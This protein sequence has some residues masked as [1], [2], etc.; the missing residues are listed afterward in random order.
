[1]TLRQKKFVILLI[2]SFA[3]AL[4]LYHLGYQ[5]FWSDE[6]ISLARASND[7]PAILINPHPEHMPLYF[8]LLHFWLIIVGSTDFIVRFLSLAFSFLVVP[9]LYR[10]GK[11]LFNYEVALWAATIAAINPFQTWYAQDARMYAMVLC[12][13]LGS[14]LL[15][16]MALRKKSAAAWAGYVVF[17]TLSIYT[18]YY[19]LLILLAEG[20]L[21]IALWLRGK[22]RDVVIGWLA[23]QV[24]IFVLY[25]PWLPRALHVPSLPVWREP[26]S[27]FSLPL[28]YLAAYSFGSTVPPSWSVPLSFGFLLILCFGLYAILKHQASQE[29]V[30]FSLLYLFVPTFLT[31][32]LFLYKPNYH[33]RYLIIITPAY[34]LLLAHGLSLLRKFWPPL[35]AL[36]LLFVALTSGYSLYNHYFDSSYGKADFRATARQIE[37]LERP[38][39]AILFDGST[40]GLLSHYYR[41]GLPIYELETFDYDDR[42]TLK[43]FL[44]RVMA[45]HHRLWVVVSDHE[46]GLVEYWLTAEAYQARTDWYNGIWLYLYSTPSQVDS[47]R[48]RQTLA[49][50]FGSVLR[51]AGY[52]LYPS[53]VP[54]G[55]IINLSLLWQAQEEMKRDHKVALRLLDGQD[56][57]WAY[58]YRQPLDGFRPT[59][60]WSAGEEVEDNYGL[61]LFPGTP[62]GDYRLEVRVYHEADGDLPVTAE[63]QKL[64]TFAIEPVVVSRAAFPLSVEALLMQHSWD[65]SLDGPIELLG[66]ELGM[67][68]AEP[69]EPFRLTLFWRASV[70]PQSDYEVALQLV[71]KDG[72]V[73]ARGIFPPGNQAYPTSQ[74][75]SGEVIRSQYNLEINATTPKGEHQLSV[76]LID[77]ATGQ[78]LLSRGEVPLTK[79]RVTGVRRQFTVPRNI[80]YPVQANL[81]NFVIFRGYDLKAT[82]L[83]ADDTVHLTLYWQAQQRM[84]TNYTVF[85]HL[86]DDND[87][88]WGQRDSMPGGGERPTTSWLEGEIV[89]DQYEMALKPDTPPGEYRVEIGMYDATTGQRLPVFAK[90]GER[91]PQ[92]RILFDQAITIQY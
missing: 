27:F 87:Q 91:L 30:F 68:V 84:D 69:G 53:P 35:G 49:V 7:V 34:Y 28:R 37:V 33:E 1:M 21:F 47:D 63:G 46:P 71:G 18:H 19:A 43:D 67:P 64:E 52:S 86:L 90:N 58:K 54:S 41:G 15:L 10:L 88:I 39:D 13:T 38:G 3:F 4:R 16:L 80:Q 65:G 75:E 82:D 6:G 29:A 31:F 23:S 26:V 2:V 40:P 50:D 11:A 42:S 51:L 81:D 14:V 78:P 25:L 12:L 57:I 45:E 44:T 59:S 8:V 24:A 66:Y 76:N 61:L 74:W 72:Q 83:K 60:A 17:I 62:P 5:S 32:L 48:A 55:D 77:K 22:Y 36:G 20:L 9:L 89:I 79:L 73:W 56:Y 70:K 92:D 85:V